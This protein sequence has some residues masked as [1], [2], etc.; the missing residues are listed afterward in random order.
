MVKI[1]VHLRKL[2]Q[3]WN[4]GITSLDHPVYM[5]TR[6]VQYNTMYE[7]HIKKTRWKAVILIHISVKPFRSKHTAFLGIIACSRYSIGCGRYG[8]GRYGL[9]PTSS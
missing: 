6:T 7:L 9:W 8:H 5:Y 3:N 2:S 1:G 4:R